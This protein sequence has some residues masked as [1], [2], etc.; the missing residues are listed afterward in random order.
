MPKLVSAIGLNLVI[1][2]CL[3][4][5]GGMVASVILKKFQISLGLLSIVLILIGYS[6]YGTIFIRSGQKPAINENDPS[7]VSRAI[8]YMEREQYGRCFNFHG[9]MM[10]YLL[11]M[12]LLAVQLMEEIILQLKNESIRLTD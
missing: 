11:N 3:L 7:N 6:S 10:G 8:A 5:F 12:K 1:I 4:I 9:D 2:I